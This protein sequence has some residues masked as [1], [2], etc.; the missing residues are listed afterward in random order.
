L[1]VIGFVGF[2]GS[3]KSEATSIAVAKSFLPVVMGDAVRSFMREQGI[4]LSEKNVGIVANQLRAK[5]GMDAIAKM[6]I[7]TVRSLSPENVVIDGLRGL[8]EVA[9]FDKELTND[10]TL[11]AISARPEIRFQ[12]VRGRGRPDDASSFEQFKEKDERELA[13]G[14]E[15]ALAAA[16]YCVQND[17]TLNE[18]KTAVS[19]LLERLVGTT[20]KSDVRISIETRIYNTESQEKVECA[21][22]NIF[23]DA[24]LTRSD[25]CVKG[26]S[27]TL[28][29]FATLLRVQRIR[30]TAKTEL[31]KGLASGSFRFVLNKQVA[32]TGKVNFSQDSLGPIFVRVEVLT[33]SELIDAITDQNLK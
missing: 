21:I 14:L 32:L 4:E 7:P 6:C 31:M 15:A 20:S 5:H 22:R 10:F 13:W 23:P 9:A 2:P 3:G 8:A 1:L 28:E 12:R 27:S 11:I 33:P 26:E 30:A 19:D 16:K 25:D 24:V 29:T 17:G 18:F